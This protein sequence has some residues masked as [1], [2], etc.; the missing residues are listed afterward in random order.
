MT[1][2]WGKWS[3]PLLS[4]VGIEQIGVGAFYY[5]ASTAVIGVVNYA[6]N[7]RTKNSLC[8]SHSSRVWYLRPPLHQ[9]YR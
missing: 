8:S 6:G 9:R 5:I 2:V 4:D 7:G 1:K 3:C